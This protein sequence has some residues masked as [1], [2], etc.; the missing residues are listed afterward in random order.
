MTPELHRPI[1]L[2]RIGPNGLEVEVNASVCECS[3]MAQRM[4]LAAIATLSC[5]F[6]LAWDIDGTLIA[7]GHL[8][9]DVVQTCVVSLEDFAARVEERFTVRCVPEGK[10]SADFDPEALDEVS[11]AD[12]TLDLGEAAAEQLAL[13]LDPYPRAPGTPEI[14]DHLDGSEVQPF[15]A[16]ASFR[17]RH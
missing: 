16:L 12:G 8:L 4:K 15:A 13:A 7:H 6:R 3:A 17:H 9:A 2:A 11:Y 10:Q 14:A 1:T 5:R